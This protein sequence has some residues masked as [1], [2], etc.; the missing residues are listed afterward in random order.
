MGELLKDKVAIV[1]GSGRGIGRAIVTLM[2]EEGAKVVVNDLGGAVDGTGA[3]AA[4]PADEVVAEIKSR[5]GTAVAN[6]DSVATP[7]GGENIIKTA[8]DNFG[9]IDVLVNNAGIVRDRMLHNMSF[10][11]FDAVIKVHLYG[12]FNCTKPAI[13]AMRQQNWG[14]IINFSSIGGGGGGPLANPGQA[15]YTAAK[16]GIISFSRTVA[17]E[18]ARKGITC[19]VVFPAAK[20]RLGWNPELEAALDKRKEAGIVDSATVIL[21]RMKG[22]EMEPEDVAPLVA[23]LATD[24]AGF[25]NGCIFHT[26]GKEI[27]LYG[28]MLPIKS[29]FAEQRWSVGELVK[30]VPRLVT[31]GLG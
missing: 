21:D 12:T 14:R 10:E 17:M 23:Y 20:T 29:I 6:Y 9:R 25:I 5:G 3:G 24:A 16:A 26:L 27:R 15:N 28:E 7:E 13:V 22:G 18:G 19:N 31:V 30:S 8:I 1:T 2:A 11:D 4:S